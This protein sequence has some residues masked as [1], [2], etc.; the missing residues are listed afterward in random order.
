MEGRV[1]FC[2]HGYWAVACDTYWDRD[3]TTAVCQQLGFPVDGE[4]ARYTVSIAV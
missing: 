1:E 3:E 2:S 4:H